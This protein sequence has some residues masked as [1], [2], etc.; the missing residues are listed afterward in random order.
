M[1][2]QRGPFLWGA[3]VAVVLHAV[4]AILG[5]NPIESERF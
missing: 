1:R 5:D 2:G 3:E 4:I